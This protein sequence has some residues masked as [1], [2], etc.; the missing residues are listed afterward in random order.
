M[1]Q[2][3]DL[4]DL[5]PLASIELRRRDPRQRRTYA[6]ELLEAIGA[7][8]RPDAAA[9]LVDGLLHGQRRDAADWREL[10]AWTTTL[11]STPTAACVQARL[12]M[13]AGDA[14]AAASAWDRCLQAG[15]PTDPML[16]LEHAQALTAAGRPEEAVRQLRAALADPPRYAFFP[17]AQTLVPQLSRATDSHLRECRIAMLG[18][19]T[20]SLLAPVLEAYCLRDRVRASIYQGLYNAVTQEVFD[21]ASGLGTFRPDIVFLLSHWRDLQLAA[22]TDDPAGVV[23]GVRDERLGLW[24]ALIDRFGCHVVQC[25]YDLPDSDSGGYL[26]SGTSGGRAAVI[27]AINTALRDAATAGVSILDVPGVQQ[28]VGR[29]WHDP[30]LWFSFQQHPAT[31]ALPELGD[32]MAAHVRAVLGLTR[33]VLVTD[34][35]NTLWKGI[36]GEDGLDGIQVGPGSP[37]GEACAALQ[38]YL[39]E[40]KAR[41]V[42]LAVCSKNNPDDA[43]LPFERHPGMRLRL[44]DFA[45]F[46]ANWDE[47]ARNLQAIASEL[48]LGLD[49]FVFLDDNPMEREWIR[50]RHPEVAVVELG[51]S[52]LQYVADLDRGRH[53]FALALSHEDRAR[54]AQYR[55]ESARRALQSS[56]ASLDEFL[57]GLGM[58]ATA[59]P[60]TRAT[61]ARVTQLVNKT[62]QFNLTTRRY[63]EAQVAE[64]A[65]QPG[66]WARAFQ[67]TDR[68]GDYGLIGVLLC[69]AGDAGGWEIDTWLMSCR[70]LGRQMELYMF[71]RL[72]EAAQQAGVRSLVGVFRPTA[73]NAQVATLLPQLGFT[74]LREDATERRYG[75]DV[76]SAPLRTATHIADAQSTAWRAEAGRP[77]D[78]DAAD[79]AVPEARPTLPARE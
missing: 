31:E 23:A 68:M 54:A 10:A 41:G 36:I 76:P 78:A 19:S 28:R 45:A 66:G 17:R 62:N 30:A 25:A 75:L 43:R 14:A 63:T 58:R 29:G 59:A 22:L 13:R 79:A 38:A 49:S 57:A 42:L 44:D 24:R 46:R 6:R 16:R 7:A 56:A 40:L 48:A 35:D 15:N 74:L 37:A 72:I 61:L 69:R 8:F 50:S 2:H 27:G 33:K 67:L 26:T 53:F 5:Q 60:I 55:D 77:L 21:P 1:S 12:L 47:K 3:T 11:P 34:L 64:L 71:D 70:A 18:T 52:P 39:L 73:K 65:A 32:L 20:T 51:R 4:T 9:L